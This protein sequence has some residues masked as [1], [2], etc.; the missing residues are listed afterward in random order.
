MNE[1]GLKQRELSAR[2][3]ATGTGT[4]F[5]CDLNPGAREVYLVGDF[6]NWNTKADRMTKTKNGFRKT[7]QLAP[8]EYQYKFLVDGQWHHDPSAVRQ[9]PNQFGSTN[10]VVR[11]GDAS[12]K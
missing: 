7:M 4:V 2:P 6:N 1:K 11:V 8:G 12:K 5:V 9:I 10:S 3:E